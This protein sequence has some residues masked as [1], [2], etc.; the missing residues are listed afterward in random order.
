MA[1]QEPRVGRYAVTG[2]DLPRIYPGT[3]DG[4]SVALKDA[5]AASRHSLRCVRVRGHRAGEPAFDIESFMGG[6]KRGS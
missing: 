3:L 1:L 4:V 5:E 6:Q 2:T